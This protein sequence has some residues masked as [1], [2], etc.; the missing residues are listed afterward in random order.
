MR[1]RRCCLTAVMK[2][3]TEKMKRRRYASKLRLNR[4]GLQ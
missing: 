1:K 3:Q 2:Y 4:T